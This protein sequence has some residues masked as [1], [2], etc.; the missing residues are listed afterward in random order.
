MGIRSRV[1]SALTKDETLAYIFLDRDAN[2]IWASPSLANLVALDLTAP[3]PLSA[4]THPDDVALCEDVF[5]VEQAGAADTTYTLDRRY[6]LVVR[7]KSPQGTWRRVALRMLNLVDDPEVEGYLLQLTLGNQ[8]L[9]TV[10]A[11]DAAAAGTTID[12]V[13]REL[14]DA[15]ETGGT[16]NALAAA[17]DLNGVCIGSSPHAPIASGD[18]RH[19]ARWVAVVEDRVDMVVPVVSNRTGE[20]IGALETCSSFPDVRPFTVALTQSVAR[21]VALALDS[22]ADRKSLR[23]DAEFDGLTGLRNRRSFR[24]GL[25]VIDEAHAVS[26][27]FVD[28]DNFKCV[29]DTY[30]HEAGDRVLL[31]IARRLTTLSLP[32][33]LVAR[34]GGDEFVLLRVFESPDEPPLDPGIISCHVAEPIEIGDEFVRVTCSVGVAHGHG[35]D[36]RDLVRRA[37]AAMYEGKRRGRRQLEM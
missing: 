20:S 9:S 30:G 17:F 16:S 28:V 33:D 6:E 18:H 2:P 31:E 8:E 24:A 26:L 7:L 22:E 14:L 12:V 3:N 27:A 10:A 13:L 11:F 4:A 36:R 5:R 29:N 23:Q 19:D 37:D 1:L 35:R 25:R 32:T 15:L 21:R 34:I